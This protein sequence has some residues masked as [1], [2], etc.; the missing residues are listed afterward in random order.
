M[1]NVAFILSEEAYYG[2]RLVGFTHCFLCIDAVSTRRALSAVKNNQDISLVII[3]KELM[4]LLTK[5]EKNELL[6]SESPF[7]FDINAK[8]ARPYRE[9]L[10]NFVKQA[11]VYIGG[12]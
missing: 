5:D 7:F 11:G 1:G 12:S 4:D 3:E 2:F 8:S 6:L 10:E 9:E